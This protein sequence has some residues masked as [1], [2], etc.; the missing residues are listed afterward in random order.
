MGRPALSPASR[1]ED[2]LEPLE[3]EKLLASPA[4]RRIYDAIRAEPGLSMSELA[5]RVDLSWTGAALHVDQLEQAGLTRSVL[6]GRRRALFATNIPLSIAPEAPALLAEPACR[7]V[8]LAIIDRPGMRVWEL[9]EEIGTSERS[10]YHHVLR[11]T[12]AGLIASTNARLYQGLTATT[13]LLALLADYDQE[14]R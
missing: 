1:F 5:R 13:E 12:K 6:G 9:C 11:L 14:R 7:A 2:R 4:R 3:K 8:A 10:A